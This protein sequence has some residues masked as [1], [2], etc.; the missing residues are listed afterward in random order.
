[1]K[2]IGRAIMEAIKNLPPKNMMKTFLIG[3]ML[4]LISSWIYILAGGET[5][6][7]VPSWAEILFYPGFTVGHYCY[8]IF[9]VQLAIL[10]GTLSVGLFYGITLVVILLLWSLLTHT[11]KKVMLGLSI[12]TIIVGIFF[13]KFLFWPSTGEGIIQKDFTLSI[14]S[15]PPGAKVYPAHTWGQPKPIGT[16][17]FELKSSYTIPRDSSDWWSA[18]GGITIEGT[19]KEANIRLQYLVAKNGYICQEL[20]PILATIPGWKTHPDNLPSELKYHAKLISEDSPYVK[21]VG[22]AVLVNGAFFEVNPPSLKMKEGVYIID[23]KS[24]K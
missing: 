18:G 19:E 20:S 1:M 3:L 13:V 7:F 15:D 12:I 9:G 17:P 24:A 11:K 16:T 21:K 23:I 22:T 14:T 5:W 6:L 2:S 4:G 10:I 8:V